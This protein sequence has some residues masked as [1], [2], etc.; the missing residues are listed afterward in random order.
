M[1]DIIYADESYK[2]IGAC[3]NVYNDKG[4]GFLE[5]VYQEC[6]SI[7]LEV[8]GIPF[9]REKR[10]DIYYRDRKLEQ[11]YIPDFI[12]YDK[13]ILELKAVSKIADVHRAQALNYLKATG[14]KL[15]IVVNFS[16]PSKLE[17]ERIVL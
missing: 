12:C 16:N 2:V 15:A 7:E 4:S 10:I 9:A 6:L 8:E 1:N 13:I 5:P 11:T 14:C 17:Y 3:L